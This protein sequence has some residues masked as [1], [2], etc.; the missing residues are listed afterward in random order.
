M[1]LKWWARGIFEFSL[2]YTSLLAYATS[3]ISMPRFM[4][5]WPLEWQ[6]IL[7]QMV[8]CNLI[9]PSVT[10]NWA[11]KKWNAFQTHT[12]WTKGF[13][14][15]IEATDH[16][17]HWIMPAPCA[18]WIF[19]FRRFKRRVNKWVIFLVIFYIVW[20]N[21]LK[22]QIHGAIRSGKWHRFWSPL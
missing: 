20:E 21:S 19:L 18:W 11:G 13:T 5:F 4:N 8:S 10:Q 1:G 7:D 3:P 9:P 12:W 15:R 22:K 17:G 2:T 16:W 6:F 14:L